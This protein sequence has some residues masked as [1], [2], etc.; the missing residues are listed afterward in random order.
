METISL[1]DGLILTVISMFLV[2][3]VLG[4]IWILTDFV[5]KVVNKEQPEAETV[6][7]QALVDVSIESNT[8]KVNPKNQFAAEMIALILASEDESNRKF[9]VIE[10]KRIK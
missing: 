10:S 4:A 3:L 6:T 2:F 5:A 1:F 7:K 9:E 8:P